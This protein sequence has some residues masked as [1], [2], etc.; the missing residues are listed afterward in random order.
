M[1][2]HEEPPSPSQRKRLFEDALASYEYRFAQRED[3]PALAFLFEKAC[4]DS[5]FPSRGIR[6][7]VPKATRWIERV[8][9]DHSCPHLVAVHE[10]VIIGSM[11]Y[12]LD[13]TFCEE[14]V[15][16]M[17]MLYVEPEHRHTAVARVLVALCVDAA[18]GEGAIAFHAPIAAEVREGSLV[19]LFAKGGFA[20]IGVIMGRSL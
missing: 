15:G 1:T 12:A 5:G 6:Y 2:L 7:S 16:V 18:K 4:I 9:F 8:L 13:D 11:S 3:A 14:P 19:N 17:H 10:D 20:P